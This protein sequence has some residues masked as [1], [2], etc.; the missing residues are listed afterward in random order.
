MSAPAA[1]RRTT[2][3]CSSTP[4]VRR[5]CSRTPGCSTD[6]L[7]ALAGRGRGRRELRDRLVADLA[8]ED[9]AR[10]GAR[11]GAG[12]AHD[13]ARQLVAREVAGEERAELGLVER[14]VGV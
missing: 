4:A 2:P 11:Q 12:R 1:W 14:A 9:L 3:S 6:G 10:R 5:R 13:V 7:R 8:L